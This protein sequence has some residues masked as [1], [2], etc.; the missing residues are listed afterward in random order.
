[1]KAILHIGTEKT[2]TTTLQAF[3]SL[4]RTQLL[5]KG[6]FYPES[7]GDSGRQEL[8]VASYDLG[9]QDDYMIA[10]RIKTPEELSDFQQRSIGKLKDEIGEARSSGAVHS[11]LIS[12]EHLQSRLTT[13]R[14]IRRLRKILS[15]F[16]VSEFL[17]VVY[18]RSP[19]EL[20]NSLYSTSVRAG[21]DGDPP[22]PECSYY[23]N[24]CNHEGTL[25]R[26]M[27]IF[28]ESSV[29]PR[30]FNRNE[31]VNGSI[32]DD[33]MNTIDVVWDRSAFCLPEMKNVGLSVMG[34]NI[35][36]RINK[37][38]PRFVDKEVN[39]SRSNIVDYIEECFP[40]EKYFIPKDLWE[41]YNNEFS[42]SNEWV[43]KAFFD[44]RP[45][46]FEN[47][48]YPAKKSTKIYG[49]ELDQIA[50]FISRIWIE[51]EKSL[52]SPTS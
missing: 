22:G 18:L 34:I 9:R 36:K 11:L 8:S 37:F 23:F 20:A 10:N 51:R 5:Q 27:K 17:V 39:R 50:Y 49:E 40:G 13:I 48:D 41:K 42:D 38:L 12:S 21:W 28:G 1:V 31:F 35:I 2:A 6:V 25:K 19:A 29:V 24:V 52:P 16:G 46:L 15:S 30:I 26:F 14:E 43:R 32:I 4:N 33:F 44:D 7:E 3:L 45:M 47:E